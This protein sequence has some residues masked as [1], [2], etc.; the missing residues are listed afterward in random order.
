MIKKISVLMGIYNCADT[1]AEA[2]DSLL[3]QTYTNWECILCDDGSADDTYAVAEEYVRKYPGHF[4]LI[5]NDV[6]RGLNHT[7]NRCLALADGEYIARMDGDDLSLP[8]RFKKEVSFLEQHPEYAI[9]STPMI[10]FD[11]NGEWGRG[12]AIEKPEKKDFARHSPVHCHAPCMVRRQAM[13]SVGGY[14]EN[15]RMLRFEDVN[16]WFKLY[17][18]GYKGYNLPDPLYMMR[19]DLAAYHRR[20]LKTR[21]NAVYTMYIGFR[22]FGWPWYMYFYLIEDAAKHLMKALIPEGI[23]MALHKRR[24]TK[25]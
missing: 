21:M 18:K 20:S 16:L 8:E 23:Y 11:Q 22:L 25:R 5:R 9:V 12:T 13:L 24:I 14:T 4:W 7:L 19:D 10:F 3:A 15:R 1:L 17:A 2:L 6:N